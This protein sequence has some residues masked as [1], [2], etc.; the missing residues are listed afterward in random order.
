VKT[1]AATPKR[2]GNLRVI[3]TDA[4]DPAATAVIADGLAGYNDEKAG[5]SDHRPL[6]V[7]VS[8]PETGEVIGGLYGRSYLGV[9]FIERFFLPE[10]RRGNRLGSRVLAIA[11]E[12]GR[13]RGCA[14][15][16]LFTLHFQ[17][18]GFYRKQGY[19]IAARLDAPP[20]GATRILMTKKLG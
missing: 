18:P 20:P 12:E 13:R 7:L 2:V 5:P 15:I 17:A 11:E 14:L 19:D 4:P 6:A 16:A 3:L 10:T 9:L 1:M 8:D